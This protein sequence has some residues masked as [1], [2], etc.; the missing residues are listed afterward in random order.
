MRPRSALTGPKA[1]L[2]KSP[3]RTN[4]T[5]GESAK[6]PNTVRRPFTT[7]GLSSQTSAMIT[8][9]SSAELACKRSSF[10]RSA[11]LGERKTSGRCEQN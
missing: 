9:M 2:W 8:K 11:A 4:A 1:L 3:M 5:G 10:S 6:P 7:P